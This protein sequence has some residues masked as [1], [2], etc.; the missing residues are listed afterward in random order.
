M[1]IEK[2]IKSMQGVLSEHEELSGHR[3]NV[4]VIWDKGSTHI[5]FL[6]PEGEENEANDPDKLY[7]SALQMMHDQMG[8]LQDKTI[9]QGVQADEAAKLS[10]AM[11]NLASTLRWMIGERRSWTQQASCG[12]TLSGGG[13]GGNG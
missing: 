12:C 13:G 2:V 4:E 5:S 1:D 11:S 9:E 7:L 6:V 10:D 3:V 8:L